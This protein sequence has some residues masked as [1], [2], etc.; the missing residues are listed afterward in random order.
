MALWSGH[1]RRLRELNVVNFSGTGVLKLRMK[2][3]LW[4][5]EFICGEGIYVC[6]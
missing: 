6:R 3:F 2:L 1:R 5:G 4:A